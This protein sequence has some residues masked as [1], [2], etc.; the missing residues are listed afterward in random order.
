[1]GPRAALIALFLSLLWGGNVVALKMGLDAVPP[2]WS[3]FWRMLLGLPLIVAWARIEGTS[4]RLER[5][6]WRSVGILAV[7]FGSQITALN[8]ATNFT[9]PAFSVVLLNSSPVFTNLVAH[10]FVAGDRLSVKRSVGLTIAF[11]GICVVFLGRPPEALASAPVLGNTLAV[12]SALVVSGRM[13]YTQKLVQIM[14]STRAVFWQVVLAELIFLSGALLFEPMTVGPL[15]A[16]AIGGLLYQGVI[17]A[18]IGFILWVRLLHDHAPGVISVFGF[19]TPLFGVLFSALLFAEPLSITLV[20]GMLFVATG[21][22]IVTLEKRDRTVALEII[23]ATEA[24]GSPSAFGAARPD[25]KL[26]KGLQS[27]AIDVAA[28]QHANHAPP[29]RRFRAPRPQRRE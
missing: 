6:E 21:I 12:I 24:D 1:M 28:A 26:E 17:V 13:V 14:P 25:S 16:R 18:G 20:I 4:L 15:T 5:G 11:F 23:E 29:Q 9:S 8:F 27:G 22:L 19:P 3:A 7:V 10:F 2:L